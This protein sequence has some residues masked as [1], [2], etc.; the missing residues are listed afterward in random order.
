[1]YCAPY[2]CGETEAL[3]SNP[4]SSWGGGGGTARN[5]PVGV[6]QPNSFQNFHKIQN[7]CDVR[8]Q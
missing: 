5:F 2:L 1:M 6:V 4:A 7:G 3:F 8:F